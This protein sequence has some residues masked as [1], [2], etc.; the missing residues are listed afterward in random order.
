[1]RL[2]GDGT[3]IWE[4]FDSMGN[5]PYHMGNG[6][7]VIVGGNRITRL[8]ADGS[9]IWVRN[10]FTE[11]EYGYANHYY[12]KDIIETSDGGFFAVVQYTGYMLLIK[13]DCEG[14]YKNITCFSTN[15]EVSTPL[16]SLS[17][18]PNPAE[19][20][21]RVSLPEAGFYTIRIIDIQGRVLH[22]YEVWEKEAEL[23]IDKLPPGLYLMSV[24]NEKGE[25]HTVRFVK[26]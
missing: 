16:L 10:Y 17:L 24:G 12:F 11:P 9:I 5:Y 8:G 15:N 18:S 13:M 4:N 21:L 7:I 1:M 14:N 2:R 19:H 26:E 25:I 6:E 20:I 23:S 22:E 3:V